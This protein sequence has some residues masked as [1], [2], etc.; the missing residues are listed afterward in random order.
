MD[1]RMRRAAWIGGVLAACAG[2][3]PRAPRLRPPVEDMPRSVSPLAR[4]EA[5]ARVIEGD[6][7]TFVARALRSSPGLEASYLRWKAAA[8]RV[9]LAGKLPEPELG[10]TGFVRAVETRVGPQRHRIALRQALPWPGVLDAG[11]DASAKQADVAAADF[12]ARAL[13]VVHRV[14]RAYWALWQVERSHEIRLA[15]ERL[16]GDLVSTVQA[17]VETGEKPV[18]EL[19]QVQLRLEHLRDHRIRHRSQKRQLA[20]ELLKEVGAPPAREV[21]LDLAPPVIALPSHSSEGLRE[22]TAEHPRIARWL[23][24]EAAHQANAQRARARRF[25]GFRLGFDYI[26]T[27]QARAS[28]VE[29]SGKDPV[30][31][32]VGFTLPVWQR[33]YAAEV[34]AAQAEA[35]VARAARHQATLSTLSALESV[36]ARIRETHARVERYTG[37]LIPQTQALYE[38][39]VAAYEVGRGGVSEVLLALEEQLEL[40]L[41]LAEARA[42]HA[43]AWAELES[44]VG[45][46]LDENAGDL[47]IKGVAP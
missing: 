12:E 3:E 24:E 38:T 32:S 11:T 31:L 1:V 10:Y 39:V 6:L 37:T 40:R 16:L 23:D 22:A 8:S 28:G 47:R 5:S 2:A 21:E 7:A 36:L 30:L 4:S 25:P 19:L 33:A 43:G 46:P 27:D 29:G 15:H 44:L 17:R 41:E 14:A 35:A 26:V 34:E 45:T 13:E 9:A 42:A 20:A 18:S